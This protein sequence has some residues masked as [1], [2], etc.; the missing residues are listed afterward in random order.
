MAEPIRFAAWADS[1]SDASGLE[2][3]S[4]CRVGIEAADYLSKRILNHLTAKEPLVPALGGLPLALKLHIEA[5][6][7]ALKSLDIEPWFV[8]SGLDIT[9]HDD[10]FRQ[11]QDEAAVNANAW[12][13]YDSH[14]AE[15]S[16]G[17]FGESKYV[18]P[19]DLFR[20]LQ[21]ILTQRNVRFL[22]A[23]YSAWAQLAYL[24][25]SQNVHAISG[26][27]DIL[28]FDCNKVITKWDF[29][30]RQFHYI[31]RD[32]C[33][34][35]L[36]KVAGNVRITEDIFVDTALLAGTP[37]L[38]S[39]PFLPE[40]HKP[41]GAVKTVLNNGKSGYT[42]VVNNQDD[43]RVGSHYVDR[44]R[45]AKL[46]VKN[47]PVYTDDGKIEPMN[48]SQLPND[49]VQYL[50]QRL[51]DEIFHYMSRGLIDP[52]ILQWR[53]TCEIFEVPPMDSGESLDM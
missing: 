1:L 44:F 38:P 28:L 8:F 46:A 27:P 4:G 9:K 42:V 19:E 41:H 15:A 12:N 22:V 32:K 37:F 34:A 20:A 5:D 48:L 39:L 52:R 3:L 50:G 13:L 25:K 21:S 53:T 43:P 24:E 45:K 16:V 2:Q 11:K 10:P 17:K 33:F 36:E 47:H 14:Q 18:T 23:P 7:T 51:P 31:K 26:S 35:D 30:A 29:D 6:L 49:A 40:N